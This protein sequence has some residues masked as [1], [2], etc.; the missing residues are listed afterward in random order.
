MRSRTLDVK[1]EQE[2]A[3]IAPLLLGEEDLSAICQKFIQGLQ[4]IIEALC[5]YYEGELCRRHLGVM[6]R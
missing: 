1:E 2:V 3:L 6:C 4:H 5:S